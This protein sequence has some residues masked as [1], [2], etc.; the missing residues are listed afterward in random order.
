MDSLQVEH[1]MQ[2]EERPRAPTAA[3]AKRIGRGLAPAELT[4]PRPVAAWATLN[5]G[6]Q[7]RIITG[8]GLKRAPAEFIAL[9]GRQAVQQMRPHAVARRGLPA[10]ALGGEAWR[11]L[12][13][14]VQGRG[15]IGAALMGGQSV[16]STCWAG[17]GTGRA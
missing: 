16:L 10:I 17:C 8:E 9:R 7:M 12:I 2:V 3:H 14:V 6:R 1:F 5:T 4:P 11:Q 15:T 13:G